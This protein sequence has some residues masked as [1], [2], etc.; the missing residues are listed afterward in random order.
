[1]LDDEILES[2]KQLRRCLLGE[3]ESYLKGMALSNLATACWWHKHP[4]YH[5]YD[6][7][8]SEDD[9]WM[10]DETNTH[11]RQLRDNDYEQALPL[12]KNAIFFLENV[13]Q[14]NFFIFLIFG[15]F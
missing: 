6:P 7:L 12:F 5:H 8:M 14:L 11:L 9:D 1:M 4:N 15:C 2:K 10:A 13:K 3:P